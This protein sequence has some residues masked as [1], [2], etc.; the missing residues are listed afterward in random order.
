M[1]KSAKERLKIKT[2][3][4][5]FCDFIRILLTMTT[6]LPIH[7]I[8]ATIHKLQYTRQSPNNDA[9][10]EDDNDKIIM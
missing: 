7:A 2:E 5:S 8:A 1:S 9:G 4:T 6:M 3:S 10:Y